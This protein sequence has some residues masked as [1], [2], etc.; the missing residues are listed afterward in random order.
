[1]TDRV[2]IDGFVETVE[3]AARRLR[4]LSDEHA[5]RRR[6]PGKWSPKEI[7]GHLIDSA[8]N[9]HVRFVRAQ[10]QD[11]LVFDGYDQDAWVRVQRYRD[12]PWPQLVTTWHH[13]N[14][15]I[16]AIMRAASDAELDRPRARHNL[17]A[18]AFVPPSSAADATLGY[19]MRD[20]VAHLEHHLRQIFP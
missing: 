6:A 16:A 2:F 8:A 14:Q 11:D 7:V 1:M 12:Q 20:Y 13:S 17:N 5:S 15:R 9:N 19:F 10:L 4:A 3:Q 18:I